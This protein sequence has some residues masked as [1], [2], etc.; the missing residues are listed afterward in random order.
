MRE[1]V[2]D[3]NP[4]K[5]VRLN[6]KPRKLPYTLSHNDI[7]ILLDID[8][9]CH[10]PIDVRNHAIMELLYSSGIRL[11]ELIQISINDIDLDDKM[12]MVL[13]KGMKVRY[14]PFGSIAA[15]SINAWI[16]VRSQL[17]K[18]SE[19]A[20]FVGERG[21]RICRSVVQ[22]LVKEVSEKAIHKRVY[23]HLLRHTCAT[24]LLESSGD[25]KGVQEIL[26]HVSIRTTQIYTH[27]DISHVK[28]IYRKT[29]PRSKM[30]V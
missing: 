9:D 11:S 19:K 18:K 26:G 28:K 24:H 14:V 5:Q 3:S 21:R 8:I 29:H 15:N 30:K 16:E 20:L 10:S 25:L 13:G 7:K 12:L 23:P 1:G 27:L 17:A 6:R 4:G 2:V 22:G